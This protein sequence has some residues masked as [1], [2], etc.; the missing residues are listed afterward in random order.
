M[1]SRLGLHPNSPILNCLTASG[2]IQPVQEDVYFLIGNLFGMALYN[3][4]IAAFPFPLAVFKKLANIQPTL[5]DLK[6]LFPTEGRY[7][8]IILHLRLCTAK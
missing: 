8:I 5:E 4:K 1:A 2:S 3:M 6:E 7:G